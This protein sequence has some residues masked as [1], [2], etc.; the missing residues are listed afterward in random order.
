[1]E[2]AI[3][4]KFDGVLQRSSCCG[5]PNARVRYDQHGNVVVS[6]ERDYLGTLT[7]ALRVDAA[8]K[9]VRGRR[10][11][12]LGRGRCGAGAL[13]GAAGAWG[14]RAPAACAPA[15]AASRLLVRRGLQRAAP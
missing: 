13:R 2:L 7:S 6:E 15:Q 10:S 8:G 4:K 14:A 12:R 1:V 3:A 11:G 5:A 9:Q